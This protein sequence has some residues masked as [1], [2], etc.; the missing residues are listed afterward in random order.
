MSLQLIIKRSN[1][2]TNMYLQVGDLQYASPATISR[3]GMVYVDPKNLGQQPY[4]DKWIN[5]RPEIERQSLI[6]LT[7]KYMNAALDLILEGNL[8]FQRVTPLKL[9]V[10]QTRVN[11]VK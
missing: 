1:L 10:P 2:I 3:A 6:Q 7:N 5:G 8:G 9:I 11:M 4:L